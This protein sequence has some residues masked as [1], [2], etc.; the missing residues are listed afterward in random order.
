M[1]EMQ[2]RASL[3]SSASVPTTILNANPD[4][5]QAQSLPPW[6]HAN[7]GSATTAQAR[8]ILQT[9]DR[10]VP[11]TRHYKLSPPTHFKPGRKWDHLRDA[12]PPLLSAP[13]PE[14]QER[15]RPFMYSGP[16]PQEQQERARVVD[17]AWMDEHMPYLNQDW[18]DEDEF[19][20]E[21]GPG[22]TYKGFSGLMYRGKWLISP[23]RQERTVHLFWVSGSFR[24]V[25]SCPCESEREGYGLWTP[26]FMCIAE[27][28]SGIDRPVG[29]A[30]SISDCPSDNVRSSRAR[31]VM[32][33]YTLLLLL[34]SDPETTV[35]ESIRTTG[36]PCDR[37]V[38]LSRC[39]WSGGYDLHA[40]TSSQQRFRSGQPV[41]DSCID[42]Y[43]DLCRL[44]CDT[45]RGLRDLG[46]VYEQAVRS[47]LKSPP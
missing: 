4:P 16:N 30:G 12:E 42:V 36:V 45:V 3:L 32:F 22:T 25:S 8:V 14:A 47:A 40:R 13:I 10:A 1:P 35:E 34:T 20:T 2:Q 19:N 33:F 43:G 23:E 44:C 24:Y 9:P 28:V 17:Q 11:H 21:G 46:R 26:L 37:V 38:V 41:R 15:W 5:H 7:D 31:A 39:A 18:M 6:V 29:V 27:T